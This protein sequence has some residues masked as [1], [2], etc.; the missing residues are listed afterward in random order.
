ME[1]NFVRADGSEVVLALLGLLEECPYC[2][3]LS[4]LTIL[5]IIFFIYL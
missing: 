1:T 3:L 2:K 4:W 5:N